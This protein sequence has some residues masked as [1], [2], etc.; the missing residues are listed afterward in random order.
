[1]KNHIIA[2]VGNWDNSV[3]GKNMK[4]KFGNYPNIF[5]FDPIYDVNKLNQL[6]MNCKGY[7]HGHSAGGT[8]PSLVE[9]MS[10]KIPILAF[11]INFNKYTLH[12]S[13]L[14]FSNKNELK[15][16]IQNFDKIDH[17]FDI[18]N[19][20]ETYLKYYTKEKIAEEYANLFLSTIKKSQCI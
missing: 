6:R 10:L 17:T 4:N 5:L 1:M 2:I 18:S 19:I 8:N 16:L 7:I 9:A 3:F 14:Y 11:N 12:N 20:Y 13:G 15:Q